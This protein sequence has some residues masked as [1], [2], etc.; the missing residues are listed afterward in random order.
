MSLEFQEGTIIEEEW[1]SSVLKG[2]LCV[3]NVYL[4][5]KSLRKYTRDARCQ[6]RMEVK[7]HDISGAGEE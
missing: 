6:D 7:E 5:R 4:E 2:G 3:C 1:W